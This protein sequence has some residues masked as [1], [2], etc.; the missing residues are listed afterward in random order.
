MP[1]SDLFFLNKNLNLRVYWMDHK[2]KILDYYKMKSV[3]KVHFNSVV[4]SHKRLREKGFID[5]LL[6][7]I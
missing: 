3:N 7:H 6:Q 2:Y 1:I 5:I 4:K